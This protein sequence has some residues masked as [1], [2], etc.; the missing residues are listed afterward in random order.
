MK[1]FRRGFRGLQSAVHIVFCYSIQKVREA[2]PFL[3][4]RFDDQ[5]AV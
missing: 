1:E 4:R 5:P 2:T 3:F